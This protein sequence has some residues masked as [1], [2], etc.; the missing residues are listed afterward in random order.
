MV[1]PLQFEKIL[2][3]LIFTDTKV[4]EKVFPYL[5]LKLFDL[6]ECKEIVKTIRKF[7]SKYENF[8][9]VKELKLFTS[10]KDVHDGLEEVVKLDISEFKNEF[11]LD[12]IQEF[13]KGKLI[14][15]YLAL[16]HEKSSEGELGAVSEIADKLKEANSFSFDD[17]VGLDLFSDDGEEK[18]YQHLHS[19]N[20]V[21]PTYLHKFDE[22]VRGGLHRK[23]VTVFIAQCVTEDTKIEYY[24]KSVGGTSFIIIG[25]IS[26]VN[27]LLKCGCEVFVK[28]PDGWVEVLDYIDKGEKQIYKLIVDSKEC[29]SSELH[30]YE[31]IDGWKYAKDLTENDK[32]LTENGYCKVESI[33]LTDE[34]KK[35]VDITVNHPNH[36]YY[37]N[38]ISSHNS[39]LGKTL[40]K[41]AVAANM[42]LNNHKV[43][44]VT[45]ELSEEYIGERI[46]QNMF[47]VDR[48]RLG[49]LSREEFGRVYRKFKDKMKNSL[50]IKKYGAGKSNVNHIVSL[51]KDL[52][53][54]KKFKTDI[55]ILDYLGIF[56]AYGVSKNANSNDIGKVK[57]QE[58]E[59]LAFEYD[60]P[61]LTSAQ[62][63]RSGYGKS[64]L[65][66]TN[67]ADA[68]GIFTETDVVIGVT[69]TEE[70]RELNPPLYSWTVLKNRFGLN[71]K[72]FRIGICYE[73]MR[74]YN[75][76]EN[77][78]VIDAN[79]KEEVKKNTENVADDIINT[80]DI[81]K[82]KKNF[83]NF[84]IE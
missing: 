40:I 5:D 73:K 75:V 48:D 19:E 10:K 34:V 23:S 17:T 66:P 60:I 70:L 4:R 52:E 44:Y 53:S 36:R 16:A 55:L 62:S 49:E 50:V 46:L 68:I 51:F 77:G 27:A 54:K 32:V 69:Q 21:I 56:S 42:I 74:L 6:Y 11:V 79:Y 72:S 47:D 35:V 58:L 45:C 28:S 22:T 1:D 65:D 2:L 80:F 12:S 9:S 41:C 83:N 82:K 31:T 15:N 61:I 81:G 24:Y 76:D 29:Y 13:I 14:F 67:I 7:Q 25:C 3:K 57:C 78:Q 26:N 63:N 30:L 8:P 64:E 18:M 33:E 39:N 71:L 84:V 20:S 38:G 37:T 43:V 59:S